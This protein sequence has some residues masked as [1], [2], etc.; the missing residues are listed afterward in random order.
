M[1]QL[2]LKKYFEDLQVNVTMAGHVR[3]PSDWKHHN[4]ITA[5][6]CL[7]YFL[8][9][10]G[11]LQIRNSTFSPR[12][13]DLFVLP[14]GA[15]ISYST[16]PDNPYR[17]MFCHFDATVG[18]IPLFQL[19]DTP[20][21]ISLSD[22]LQAETLFGRLIERFHSSNAFAG[23]AVKAAIFELLQFIWEQEPQ[24]PSAAVS[25]AAE[26]WNDIL[27]YID[28]HADGP[29]TIDQIADNF[30]YSPN[31][32]FRYF[33]SAFGISPHQY[34]IQKRMEKAKQLLLTTDW[35]TA[36]IAGELGMERSHFSRLFLASTDMTPRQFRSLHQ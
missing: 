24:K 30:N 17:Q 18:Q 12:T 11:T 1:N 29:L 16:S 33:K 4:H 9:G 34:I 26:R 22:Q 10:E 21:H 14:A 6:N 32:F 19:I 35:T 23:L 5:N 25:P 15:L 8:E 13:G 36:R 28:E 20:L 27:S 2:R 3:V 31:Y 7:Y